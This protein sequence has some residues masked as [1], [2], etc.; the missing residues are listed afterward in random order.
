M[1]GLNIFFGEDHRWPGQFPTW[2]FL[3]YE[4]LQAVEKRRKD[5]HVH[6]RYMWQVETLFKVFYEPSMQTPDILK[7]RTK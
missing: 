4:F 2:I 3:A 1:Q 7:I 5:P 6:Y